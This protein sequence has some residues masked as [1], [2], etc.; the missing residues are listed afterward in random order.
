[1][2]WY[3]ILGIVS[4][5]L[6]VAG[7]LAKVTQLLHKIIVKAVVEGVAD[8]LTDIQSQV[9]SNGGTSMK[10]TLDRLDR[11]VK[12]IGEGSDTRFNRIDA[13]LVRQDSRIDKLFEFIGGK[14]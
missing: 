10:D 8:E 5:A 9:R 4:A 13:H 3:V 6:G 7:F 12:E 11:R 1:M 2:A 14:K